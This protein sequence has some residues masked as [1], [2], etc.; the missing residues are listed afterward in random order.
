ML[1][2]T[3]PG[4]P[5][6]KAPWCCVTPAPVSAPSPGEADANPLGN[7]SRCIRRLF[8]LL[9]L[10]VC[11]WGGCLKKSQGLLL[12]VRDQVRREEDSELGKKRK[13]TRGNCWM[14]PKG[15]R[16]TLAAAGGRGEG[17]RKVRSAEHTR[18]MKMKRG[19]ME[20]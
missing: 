7:K 17:R 12:A 9:F 8:F 1:K 4:D 20:F 6:P 15:Q 16:K 11:V 2:S 19:K 3:I 14:R 18:E 10:G 5:A 13:E